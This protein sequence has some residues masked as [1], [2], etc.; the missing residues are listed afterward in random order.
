MYFRTLVKDE[1]CGISSQNE[2][3]DRMVEHNRHVGQLLKS[4]DDMG[5]Q[6]NTIASYSQ[7]M[8]FT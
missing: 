5:I 3:S 6:V 1:L 8:A 4:L 2:C 7:I